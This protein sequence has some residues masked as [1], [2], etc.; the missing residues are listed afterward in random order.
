MQGQ[1]YNPQAP[2]QRLQTMSPSPFS[3]ATQ[4]Y[5]AQASPSQ[6][7]HGSRVNTPQNGVQQYAQGMPYGGAPVQPFTPPP[8]SAVNGTALAQ[9]NQHLQNQQQQQRI[10]EARLRQMQQQRQHQ[11]GALNSLAQPQVRCQHNRWLQFAHNRRNSDRT[12]QNSYCGLSLN[13]I[14]KM[15]YHSV[16][17]LSLL[18]GLSVPCNCSSAL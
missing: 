5:G 17:T 7:E 12:T 1:A 14:N 18:E 16:L 4:T 15:V 2:H 8:G 9:Y 6:S 13:G 10:N 11:A 3:P